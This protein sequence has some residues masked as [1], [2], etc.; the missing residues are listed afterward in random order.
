MMYKMAIT[1]NP[2]MNKIAA[3]ANLIGAYAEA[4][5]NTVPKKKRII[6]T[7]VPSKDLES[8]KENHAVLIIQ[9]YVCMAQNVHF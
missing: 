2:A 8:I 9:L 1:P 6:T 3:T 4:R 5:A 7:I